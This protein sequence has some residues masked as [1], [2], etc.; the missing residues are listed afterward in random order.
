[1]AVCVG[2]GLEVDPDS[3]V[4]EVLTDPAGGISCDPTTGLKL[5]SI[6]TALLPSVL[7][8]ISD[9]A[10]N[11]IVR[12]VDGLYAPCPDANVSAVNIGAI[13]NGDLPF[14]VNTGGGVPSY[15]HLSTPGP[16]TA[17]ANDLC[18]NA[19]GII[20]IRG[21]SIFLDA[22]DNFY[23]TAQLQIKYNGGAWANAD[24]STMQV[25]ENKTGSNVHT[26]FSNFMEVNKIDVNAG[27]SVTY[28]ARIEIAVYASTAILSGPV[29]FEFN[30]VIPQVGCCPPAP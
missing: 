5:T 23:C 9:D 28:A 4:L 7:D 3:G 11:G 8:P 1:M 12:R 21:G 19:S 15:F 6:P 25:F 18:C 29:G 22:A 10:C 30:W 13:E 24:P 27:S 20:T 2:C 26:G 16:D 14:E 17:I